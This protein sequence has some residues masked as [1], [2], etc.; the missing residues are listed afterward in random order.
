CVAF[1]VGVS[2]PIEPRRS[3]FGPHQGRSCPRN[4]GQWL[5]TSG[6][7]RPGYCGRCGDP[8]EKT[9]VRLTVRSLPGLGSR[10]GI[11]TMPA[12]HRRWEKQTWLALTGWGVD[13]WTE[14]HRRT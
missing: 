2:H 14:S 8:T 1:T 13:R 4:L 6:A 9:A 11:A 3:T 10:C 12:P 7:V 5:S